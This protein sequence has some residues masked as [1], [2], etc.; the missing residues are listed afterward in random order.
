M[1]LKYII[2]YSFSKLKN[3]R[4]L[5][6]HWQETFREIKIKMNRL[7][8]PKCKNLSKKKER[9]IVY[10]LCIYENHKLVEELKSIHANSVKSKKKK[11]ERK[12]GKKRGR[13]KPALSWFKGVRS[14]RTAASLPG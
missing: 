14:I 4:G 8:S 6:S 5:N 1:V 9:S 7:Y 10:Y 13:K 12:I 11:K 2:H 3:I